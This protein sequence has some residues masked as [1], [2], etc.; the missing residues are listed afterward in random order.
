MG[1]VQW[2]AQD[3][4]LLA[5]GFDA[6]GFMPMNTV[7]KNGKVTYAVVEPEYKAM[8]ETMV[9]WY[10]K[11]YIDQDSLT[12][13]GNGLRAKALNGEV[14]IIN[15]AMSA[16]TNVISDAEAEGNGANWVALG[17]PRVAEGH[18]T[19]MINS[20]SSRTTTNSV[21]VTTS[22]TEEELKVALQFINYAFT[23]EGIMYMNFGEEGVSYELDADG[24]PQ[25]TAAVTEDE[26]G[27]NEA[28]KKY[29]V[30]AGGFYGIQMADMVAAKNHPI[31]AEAV[32]EWI[33][34]S[35]VDDNFM[36]SVSYTDEEND[37]IVDIRAQ[38]RTYMSEE[39]VKFLT[40]DRPISEWDNF[41]KELY[42]LDMQKFIDINQAAYERW[43]EN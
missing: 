35:V 12:L 19:S 28:V 21:V 7:L 4:S 34:N 14:G 13:D 11:G 2:M 24:K 36:P 6:L 37:E 23:E 33:D 32:Y 5:S 20:S 17:Y 22:A 15:A 3:S 1:Y 39:T 8:M 29:T 25:F 40:G 18:P 9:D 26:L 42:D 27:L 30:H 41:I 10:S 16:F 38:I 31:V 43:L